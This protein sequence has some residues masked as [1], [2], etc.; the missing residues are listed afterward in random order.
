MTD[1]QTTQFHLSFEFE[2]TMPHLPPDPDPPPDDISPLA[3]LLIVCFGFVVLAGGLWFV[4]W[5]FR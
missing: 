5:I 1:K 4:D 2:T 3:W